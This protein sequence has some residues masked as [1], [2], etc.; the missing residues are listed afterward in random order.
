MK[1]V[2]LPALALLRNPMVPLLP[3]EAL[4]LAKKSCVFVEL[5]V[6][7]LPLIVN[8][9]LDVVMLKMLPPLLKGNST[10]LDV[11]RE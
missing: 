6:M 3:L 9:G 11:S 5:L 2:L 8:T 7:P 4:G 10:Y 1:A